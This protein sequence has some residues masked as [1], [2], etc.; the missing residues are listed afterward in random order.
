MIEIANILCP[1]DRSDIARRAVEYAVA[2]AGA[3]DAHLHV[4][5][6]VES[7]LPPMPQGPALFELTEEL[8]SSLEEDLN[9]F[10]A[11]LL[12]EAVP[13]TVHVREGAV[14]AEILREAE[15]MTDALIVIGTHGRGGFERLVMGSV[16]AK[17][18]RTAACPVLV[19]PPGPSGPA[20]V[21]FR[22]I[23]CATDF[24][25]ASARALACAQVLAE[26]TSAEVSLVHVLE[27]PFG[28]TTGPDAVTTLRQNLEAEAKA[29]L[30]ALVTAADARVLE[31][32]VLRGKPSREIVTLASARAI[33]LI[34][35]GASG[36]G[37]LDMAVLG[38]TTHQ[39]LHH[40]PCPVLT[41]P[42]GE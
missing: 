38:S 9:W 15:A 40:P 23:L 27:W 41:V 8:R 26:P 25:K 2:L 6:I 5:E 39:V 24:S 35:M 12:D 33:D 20:H 29:Q 14:V 1:V 16:A 37:A 22:R 36:R 30:A 31:T 19:V 3:H 21:A 10:V 18:I 4:V 17:V 13:T 28:E 7:G 11:P 42:A 32:V 34:V